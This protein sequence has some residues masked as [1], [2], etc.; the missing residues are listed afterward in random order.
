V[1]VGTAQAQ[2]VVIPF[3]DMPFAPGAPGQLQDPCVIMMINE[4]PYETELV[5]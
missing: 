2:D 4:D 3:Q 5:E 1:P